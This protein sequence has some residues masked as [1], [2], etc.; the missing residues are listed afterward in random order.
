VRIALIAMLERTADDVGGLRAS[1]RL[2]GK[3]LV[4]RQLDFAFS[5]GCEKVACLAPGSGPDVQ[6]AR[7]YA[8]Q[9]GARFAV[10][11]GARHLLGQVS[12]QDE[13]LVLADGLLPAEAE[14]AAMLTGPVVLTLPADS[15]CPAGFERIDLNLAWAGAMIVSGTMVERLSD[16]PPD[17]DPVSAL[18]RIALQ[19]RI[20]TAGVPETALRDQTWLIAKEAG[21]L[22]ALEQDWITRYLPKA[23]GFVPGK[24]LVRL[25]ASTLGHRL[26]ERPNMAGI[27]QSSGIVLALS[28]IMLANLASVPGGFALVAL[29]WLTG[30]LGQA[31]RLMANEGA[32]P[33]KAARRLALA[34][35]IVTDIA[36][37]A[38]S[39][40]GLFGQRWDRVTLAALPLLAMRI[41]ASSGL[42]PWGELLRD[43]LLV[44]MAFGLA[45]GFGVLE[46]SLQA[47]SLAMLG[48]AAFYPAGRRG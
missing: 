45:A 25:A 44:A 30:Q 27:L 12:A 8:E 17:I 35:S 11:S 21:Q 31:V 43:R 32:L 38:V 14:A 41:L 29:S 13:V 46:P 3:S 1:M 47:V 9:A 16:L 23:K 40:S 19:S 48:L 26:L 22:Q 24:A 4:Q 15:A 5:L 42:P 37:F 2:A 6:A 28:G 20:R 10:I 7:R 33:G 18:L 34:G 39:L 36:L